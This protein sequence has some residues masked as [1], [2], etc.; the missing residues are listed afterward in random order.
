MT[1]TSQV[2]T[3]DT[4]LQAAVR[5]AIAVSGQSQRAW[6]KAAGVDPSVISR[7]LAEPDKVISVHVLR[8]IGAA[9]GQPVGALLGETE[10]AAAAV[11]EDGATIDIP[12]DRLFAWDGNPRVSRGTGEPIELADSL[13]ESGQ[14]QSLVVRP[15]PGSEDAPPAERQYQVI[16]GNRRLAAARHL[17]STGRWPADQPMRC[18]VR[19]LG[20][21]EALAIAVAENVQR[22]DMHPMDE[23]E[24]L[25]GLVAG[26]M[27]ARVIAHA[28]GKTQRWVQQRAQLGRDLADPVKTAFREGFVNVEQA[29]D[30]ARWPKPLQEW[31]LPEVVAHPGDSVHAAIWDGLIP[32]DH[33]LFDESESKTEPF[34][35]DGVVYFADPA[36]AV[37]RQEDAI[38]GQMAALRGGWPAVERTRSPNV[39][40]AF[41]RMSWQDYQVVPLDGHLPR[42]HDGLRRVG[43]QVAADPDRPFPAKFLA[44][45][46]DGDDPAEVDPA[47]TPAPEEGMVDLED[48]LADT[49]VYGCDWREVEEVDDVV[50]GD[51]PPTRTAFA[52][53][54]EAYDQ[55]PPELA[56]EGESDIP[57]PEVALDWPVS[58]GERRQARRAWTELLQDNL[59]EEPETARRFALLLLIAGNSDQMPVL[60]EFR[61]APSGAHIVSQLVVDATASHHARFF[62]ADR[63]DRLR[64]DAGDYFRVTGEDTTT[65][66][67]ATVWRD[68]PWERAWRAIWILPIASVDKLLAAAAAQSLNLLVGNW[69][70]ATAD[71]WLPRALAEALR[72]DAQAS[73]VP[74]AAYLRT[75]KKAELVTIARACG[76]ATPKHGKMKVEEIIVDILAY[77]DAGGRVP[78]PPGMRRHGGGSEVVVK[79]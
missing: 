37:R 12:L 64:S 79:P 29:R 73:W 49:A 3:V 6:A 48:A 45:Y 11:V 16:A 33:A 59:V 41:R 5:G 65:R 9:V 27:A 68:E 34:E 36:E 21:T 76:L 39:L 54:E 78:L 35:Y 74:D 47:D 13:A 19:P 2:E 14:L 44:W 75:L 56:D 57:P 25:A 10:A 72:I 46:A 71:S 38:A 52:D 24:A 42:E 8:K 43:I 60:T 61:W 26:G 40:P 17:V 69:A 31:V 22:A 62:D 18:T 7:V 51:D 30:L 58:P 67:G 50:P 32:V 66:D 20:D 28:V 63:G 15:E 70:D 55:E 1:G 77:I 4:P 23:G 53:A